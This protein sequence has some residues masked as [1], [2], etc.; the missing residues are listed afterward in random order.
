MDPIVRFFARH[1]VLYVIALAGAAMFGTFA[2]V[3]SFRD[4]TAARRVRDLGLT[5]IAAAEVGGMVALRPKI[6]EEQA[7]LDELEGE[8]VAA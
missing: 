8:P 1:P 3:Q 6:Q 7:F 2:L 4:E 5:A